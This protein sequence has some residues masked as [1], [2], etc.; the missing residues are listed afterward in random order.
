MD[1]SILNSVKKMVGVDASL[2]VFDLD[3]LT[4]INA[5][6][7]DLEQL[8]IGPVG[9]FM[10]EDDAPTWDA[11]LG[12]DPRLSSVKSYMYFRVRLMF[13]PPQTGYLIDSMNK[14][15]EKMEWRLNVTREGDEW[16]DPSLPA[17]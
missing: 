7:S 11:F 12:A 1:Q 13:D 14:Q 6:F 15:V 2:T 5:V 17:A 8:G 16:I 4:H 3:I 9:G 10:I